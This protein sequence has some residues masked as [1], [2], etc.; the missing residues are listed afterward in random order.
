MITVN[1]LI[2][3]RPIFTRSAVNVGGSSDGE[4][5]YDVDDGTRIVH[6]RSDGAVKLAKM[7][8][9]TIKEPAVTAGAK[10]NR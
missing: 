6:V 9:D 4:C 3:G 5:H 2:N 8:L 1:I 10:G 7:M